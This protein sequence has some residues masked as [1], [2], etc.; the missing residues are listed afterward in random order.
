MAPETEV[1]S[2]V[3]DASA[4]LAP[5]FRLFLQAS[6]THVLFTVGNPPGASTPTGAGPSVILHDVGLGATYNIVSCKNFMTWSTST[7]TV[8]FNPYSHTS[9]MTGSPTDFE[10]GDAIAAVNAVVAPTAYVSWDATPGDLYLGLSAVMSSTDYVQVYIGSK[11]GTGSESADDHKALYALGAGTPSL[12]T[13]FNALYHVWWRVSGGDQGI[14]QFVGG[15]WA[16]TTNNAFNVQFNLAAAGAASFAEFA[17]P[18]TSIP[19]AG[20]DLH[21]MGG[22]WTG[23]ATG[24]LAEWPS[25]STPGNTDGVN[26]TA[27]Q[28]EFLNGAFLPND[29]TNA[30]KQ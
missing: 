13:G 30:N 17:I 19:T 7:A 14:D 3:I 16:A 12:P 9:A 2:M 23:D 21:L 6:M 15:A 5:S 4:R 24:N 1:S 10:T 27:W 26:W 28:A 11:N 22:D 25:A 18:L 29:P 8:S 20:T